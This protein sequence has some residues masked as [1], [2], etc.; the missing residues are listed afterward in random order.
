MAVVRRRSGDGVG[1]TD[2]LGD[3]PTRV[4]ALLLRLFF[5]PL[6]VAIGA[7]VAACGRRPIFRQARI[8]LNCVPFT[9]LKFRTIDDP[10]PKRRVCPCW[11]AAF[12]GLAQFLR[13]TRL[14]EVP[15]LGSILLGQMA[16]V[17]PRPL[18]AVE[19]AE[20]GPGWL[21]RQAVRPGLTGLAQLEGGNL[22]SPE[23][24]LRADLDYIERRST[25]SD[26]HILLSTL[27]RVVREIERAAYPG[28]AAGSDI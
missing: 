23:D 1:L 22:L 9:I 14:D 3:V 8:G 5:L 13:R 24:K 26:V 18:I 17:G 27:P 12:A 21:R 16:F 10:Q 6:L 19:L 15:Q 25:L 28:M 20:M 11:D 2:R 7:S 4:A